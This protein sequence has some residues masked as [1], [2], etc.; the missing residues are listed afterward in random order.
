MRFHADTAYNELHPHF[1]ERIHR[2]EPLAP[3]VLSALVV[4]RMS[5]FHL[6]HEK[7]WWTWSGFVLN[8]IGLCSLREIVRTCCMLTQE[9]EVLWHV[10]LSKRIVLR[11]KGMV[12]PSCS[13][14]PVSAGL[15]CYA[16][17]HL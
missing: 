7:N 4:Q 15:A 3:I 9:S 1:Q 12:Q 5:G 16:N 10:L 8:G 11:I 6:K 13:L 2:N 14:M 17:S